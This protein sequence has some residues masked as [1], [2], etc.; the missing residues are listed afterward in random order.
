MKWC[1]RSLAIILAATNAAVAEP[2]DRDW[3][4]FGTDVS[5]VAG[6]FVCVFDAK[7]IAHTSDGKLQV[8]IECALNPGGTAADSNRAAYDKFEGMAAKKVKDGYVPPIIHAGRMTSDLIEVVVA[9]ELLADFDEFHPF[10]ELQEELDCK[11]RRRRMLRSDIHVADSHTTDERPTEWIPIGSGR[12]ETLL[13][14][15][16][17]QQ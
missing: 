16:C 4:L 7:S 10:A 13:M 5:D 9:S 6:V 11:Q 8:P 17:G 1:L 14:L 2:N 3:K 15:T 12:D